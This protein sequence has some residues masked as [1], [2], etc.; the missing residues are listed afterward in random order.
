MYNVYWRNPWKCRSILYTNA[1]QSI[2]WSS[3]VWSKISYIA[4]AKP[5]KTRCFYAMSTFNTKMQSFST[6]HTPFGWFFLNVLLV[7]FGDHFFNRSFTSLMHRP[8]RAFWVPAWGL[9]PNMIAHDV[10]GESYRWAR[11]VTLHLISCRRR[12]RTR[13]AISELVYA[14]LSKQGQ[15]HSLS[16]ENGFYSKVNGY[17]FTCETLSTS[18]RFTA[19]ANWHWTR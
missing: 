11:R 19:M 9:W 4:I 16:Y 15:V 14:S 2:N 5:A 6:S 13:L 10:L 17:S 18:P 12:L 3:N 1:L 8:L 7:G